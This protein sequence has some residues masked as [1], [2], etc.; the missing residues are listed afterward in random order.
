MVAIPPLARLGV[1][2]SSANWT[3]ES[4]FR[5]YAPAELGIHVTRIRMGS[6]GE[7]SQAEIEADI[8]RCAALLADVRVDLIDL[9][10]TA[11][12]M[13]RGPEGE[14][15]IVGAIEQTT[16][17]PAFTATGAAVDALRAVGIE[18]PLLIAPNGASATAR[19]KAFLEAVGFDVVGSVGLD[20]GKKSN[21]ATPEDWLAA[22]Q[23]IDRP[24]ADG[25][26]FS[27][28]NTRMMEAIA[29][30][31]AALDKPAVTSVQASLW[32]AMERLA[33]RLPEARPVPALGR[34]FA[35]R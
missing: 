13:E 12:M 15:A 19:E 27:G 35:D 8:L 6:G 10:G 34:L 4:Y 23:S 16:G 31:E 33:D 3:L 24:E 26:F 29:P 25:V 21:E 7:R 14:A 11:I 17:T 32:M 9:Q 30:T 22:A 1:I 20:L 2:L 18:R 5:A 28:S